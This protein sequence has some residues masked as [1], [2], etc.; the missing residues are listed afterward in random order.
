MYT[1]ISL[2]GVELNTGYKLGKMLDKSQEKL[3][4]CLV[5]H[6]D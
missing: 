3:N 1:T 5:T 2:K 6:S 4:E